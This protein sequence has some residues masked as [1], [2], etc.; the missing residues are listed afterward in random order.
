M[1]YLTVGK[2]KV[3]GRPCL[4]FITIL[5]CCSLFAS[6]LYGTTIN[7]E[8]LLPAKKISSSP[9]SAVFMDVVRTGKQIVAVGEMGIIL[10]SGDNGE[11]WQQASVPVSV[12]LT[13]VHFPTPDMG[14]AVGH[15]GVILHS[16]DG[17]KTWQKQLDGAQINEDMLKEV[18][19]MLSGKIQELDS[20]RKNQT[21]DADA[22][23]GLRVNGHESQ[24]ETQLK[25]LESEVVDLEFLL[26]DWQAAVAEGPTKPFFDVFFKDE[27]EGFVVG[28]FGMIMKTVDAGETWEFMIK[29]MSNLCGNHYYGIDSCGD[30][31]FIAG[32]SVVVYESEEA[33][34]MGGGMLFS[35]RDGG[36]VWNRIPSPSEGSFFG[37]TTSNDCHL[38][39]AYGLL[40]AYRSLDSGNTWEPIDL[41]SPVAVQGA[42]I[43]KNGS[44]WLISSQGNIYRS[45][46]SAQ[47]FKALSNGFH[48]ALAI[49]ECGDDSAIIAGLRGLSKV[50]VNRF[51][52]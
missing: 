4:F 33:Y 50:Y 20:I 3:Y 1:N 43:F 5:A 38:V 28:S 37:I 12:T 30:S 46:D 9:T 49:A 10:I 40:G 14:W 39:I 7:D 18:E 34:K 23:D 2:I 24:E 52:E 15:Q 22:D 45:T 31:M 27:K 42:S 48:G 25:I 21:G 16:S 11:T 6:R 17:G 8:L 47:S 35:S 19:E 13:A 36:N 44:V 29:C 32:E 41:G 26:K 51:R